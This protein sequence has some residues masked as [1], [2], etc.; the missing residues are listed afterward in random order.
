MKSKIALPIVAG[1]IGLAAIAAGS[2]LHWEKIEFAHKM[3][4]VKERQAAILEEEKMRF[5]FGR[6]FWVCQKYDGY[7]GMYSDCLDAAFDDRDYQP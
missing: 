3:R 7:K 6:R 5:R 4:G 1:I 2:I